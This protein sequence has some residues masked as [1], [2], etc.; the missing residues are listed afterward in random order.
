MPLSTGEAQRRLRRFGP[1]ELEGSKPRGLIV[2][3]REIISEPMFLLLLACSIVYLLFGDLLEGT[4]LSSAI[5][6]VIFITF[7]QTRRTERTLDA[8]RD[9]S[10]PRALVIRDGL[11]LT[12]TGTESVTIRRKRRV[13][14]GF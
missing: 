6:I 1:N 8:L 4:L 3:L 11:P 12:S 7:I 13:K 10:S 14:Y 9:L 5:F 2:L